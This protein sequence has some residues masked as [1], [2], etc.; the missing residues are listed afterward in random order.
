MGM[1]AGT[2]TVQT[3]CEKS[4]SSPAPWDMIYQYYDCLK[5]GTN[6]LYDPTAGAGA[7]STRPLRPL[8]RSTAMIFGDLD[9]AL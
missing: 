7:G 5:M 1:G 9:R 2:P 6:L 8:A 3:L 4:P